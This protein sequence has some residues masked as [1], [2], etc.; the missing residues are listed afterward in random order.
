MIFLRLLTAGNLVNEQFD[1]WVIENSGC[2]DRLQMNN[3]SHERE[4]L[5]I[6]QLPD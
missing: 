3:A 1:N 4:A 6:T 2:D 5:Q